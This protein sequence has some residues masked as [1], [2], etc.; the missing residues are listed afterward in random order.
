MY[1]DFHN[2]LI[3]H[4]G[5][6]IP[7]A[8]SF[9]RPSLQLGVEELSSVSRLLA[10]VTLDTGHARPLTG[11]SPVKTPL[12]RHTFVHIIRSRRNQHR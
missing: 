10:I 9:S 6:S 12:S 2:I 7:G 4:L 11:P 8:F 5:F 1:L 3:P